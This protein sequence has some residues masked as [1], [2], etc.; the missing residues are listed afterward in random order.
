MRFCCAVLCGSLR[1]DLRIFTVFY[2]GFHLLKTLVLTMFIVLTWPYRPRGSPPGGPRFTPSPR[3]ER[4]QQA[5][6]ALAKTAHAVVLRNGLGA[7]PLSG[8][9]IE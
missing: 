1:F 3:P 4:G 7:A 6:C 8:I 9:T 5:G 2:G